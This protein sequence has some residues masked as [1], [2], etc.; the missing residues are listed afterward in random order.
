V[1]EGIAR[2][3]WFLLAATVLVAASFMLKPYLAEAV[4]RAADPLARALWPGW[5]ERIE[6]RDGDVIAVLRLASAERAGARAGI[7][8]PAWLAAPALGAAAAFAAAAGL[9]RRML[10]AA[11]AAASGYGLLVIAGVLGRSGPAGGR[12]GV[13]LSDGASRRTLDHAARRRI[14]ARRLQAV[15]SD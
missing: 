15:F 7:V 1:R 8:P 11:L 5:I 13:A 14:R 2:A 12:R 3:G 6:A 4:A 9:Y 10:A